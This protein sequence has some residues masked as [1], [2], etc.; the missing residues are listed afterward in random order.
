MLASL[1]VGCVWPLSVVTLRRKNTK[2]P[3]S[4]TKH[5]LSPPVSISFFNYILHVQVEGGHEKQ[6]AEP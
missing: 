3:F 2:N 4:N 6:T 1:P 5:T